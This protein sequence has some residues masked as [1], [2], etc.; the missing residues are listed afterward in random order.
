[1]PSPG[2][3]TDRSKRLVLVLLLFIIRLTVLLNY[4][5]LSL[6]STGLLMRGEEKILDN[7]KIEVASQ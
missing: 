7:Q 2:K 1:M 4:K 3:N 5:A 6:L